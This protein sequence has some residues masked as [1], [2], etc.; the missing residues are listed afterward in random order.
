M[1]CVKHYHYQGGMWA[2]LVEGSAE[3]LMVTLKSM[4]LFNHMKHWT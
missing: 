4:N 2:P 1:T 3:Q